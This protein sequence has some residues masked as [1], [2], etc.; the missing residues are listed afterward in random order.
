MV[1]TGLLLSASHQPRMQPLVTIVVATFNSLPFLKECFDSIA[2]QSYRRCE[3][4]VIDNDSTDGTVEFLRSSGVRSVI[5]NDKNVGFAAAQN[6]G[7]KES[8]GEWVLAL[9]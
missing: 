2:K 9:N 5:F 4:V 6:Q 7:I 1:T 8:S 3:L